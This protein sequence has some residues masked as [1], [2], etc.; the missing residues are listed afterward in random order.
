MVWKLFSKLWLIVM[1]SAKFNLLKPFSRLVKKQQLETLNYIYK[2]QPF[3]DV[4]SKNQNTYNLDTIYRGQPFVGTPNNY[5]KTIPI[6]GVNHPDVDYWL[7]KI[8]LYGG[9]ASSTTISALNT[10]CNSIDTAG[11]RNKFIRLNLF[12]GNNLNA[13]LVPLYGDITDINFN[14]NFNSS[15]YNET[16]SNGGLKGDGLSKGLITGVSTSIIPTAFHLSTYVSIPNTTISLGYD[17]G[18]TNSDSNDHRIGLTNILFPSPSYTFACF[19]LIN[20]PYIATSNV[21]GFYIGNCL[22]TTGQLYR[23][24]VS[25]AIGTNTGNNRIPSNYPLMIFG[26]SQSGSNS[27]RNFSTA[28]LNAY[29]A[30]FS[31]TN[32]EA[33]TFNT[34]MQIFQTALNRNV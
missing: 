7:Y 28:R 17:I 10:F 23:N 12:C 1:F 25:V 11:L 19:Q 21:A 4:I 16:G 20:T 8:A 2:A 29:S 5:I 9:T 32:A 26:G 24:G 33:S 30:G 15:D 34:I 22:T 3:C 27:M 6:T 18:G 31:M 13:C 14:N